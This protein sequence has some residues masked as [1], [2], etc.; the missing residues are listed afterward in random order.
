MFL[1]LQQRLMD[2]DNVECFDMPDRPKV[3]WIPLFYIERLEMLLF[4][5]P[6]LAV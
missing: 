3:K 6:S 4:F 5:N 1:F 2:G